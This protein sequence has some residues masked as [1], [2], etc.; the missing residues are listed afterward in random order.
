MR[1]NETL[2]ICLL[3]L[4]SRHPEYTLDINEVLLG[5]QSLGT[6][7]WKASDILELLQR[8][9]PEILHA[10]ALLVL[11]Q[12]ERSIYLMSR[13]EETPA[14]SIHGQGKLPPYQGN[15]AIRIE[16]IQLLHSQRSSSHV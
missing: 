10:K 16:K 5:L 14:F 6:D 9:Q 13:S 15:M 7:G 4:V 8:T 11:D 3:A 1:L 2:Q 12:Q